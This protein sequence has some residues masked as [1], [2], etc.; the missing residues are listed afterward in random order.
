MGGD[1]G[2]RG[3]E[4]RRTSGSS[5]SPRER[6]KRAATDPGQSLSSTAGNHIH[7]KSKSLPGHL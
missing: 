7:I 1:E 3:K 5:V 4:C 2:G 6:A